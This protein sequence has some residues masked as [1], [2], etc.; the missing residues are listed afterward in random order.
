M[1]RL[2]KLKVA[3]KVLGN[4]SDTKIRNKIKTDPTFPA[5]FIDGLYMVDLDE[6]DIWIEKFR[7]GAGAAMS[8]GI[9]PPQSKPKRGRPVKTRK[10][11]RV[12]EVNTPGW[13]RPASTG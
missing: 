3:R 13:E 5:Y 8:R 7:A 4:W 1:R 9:E 10:I 12:F 2:A 6:L 11:N